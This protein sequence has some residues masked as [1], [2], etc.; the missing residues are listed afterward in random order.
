MLAIEP[1][2]TAALPVLAQISRAVS[3]LSRASAG[4]PIILSV[5]WIRRSGTEAQKGRLFKFY[6]HA[7]PQRTVESR[8][9]GRIDEVGQH[10]RIGFGESP[11]SMKE[12]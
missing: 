5:C 1:S 8:I 11:T 9:A 6:C 4:R 7:L 12:S 3:R 10:H 2:M